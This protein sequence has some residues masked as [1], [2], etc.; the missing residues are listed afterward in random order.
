MKLI[1]M[2]IE[3][4]CAKAVKDVPGGRICA[5]AADG[6]AVFLATKVTDFTPYT[7][8]GGE[9]DSPVASPEADM[10]ALLIEHEF[11]LILLE[12]GVEEKM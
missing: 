10:D 2:G 6:T 11:R 8:S 3:Y 9:W 12:L 4:P 1:F 5:Y 7:L